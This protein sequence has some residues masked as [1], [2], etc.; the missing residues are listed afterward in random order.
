M[1]PL[2]GFHRQRTLGHLLAA[3][4][5]V[6]IAVTGCAAS[7]SGASAGSGGSGGDAGSAAA[8][9]SLDFRV[10]HGSGPAVQHWTLR[11]EPP[12][13]THPAPSATCAAL[14]RLKNPFSPPDRHMNCPMIRLSDR[15]I[16]VSGT[17]FGKK[18]HRVILDGGCDVGLFTRLHQ[19]FH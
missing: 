5:A 13:G 18:V 16:V 8:K 6:C 2:G 11:C 12:G 7:G 15:R 3:L 17:W 14:L 9:V 4:A 10:T 1:T 19:I